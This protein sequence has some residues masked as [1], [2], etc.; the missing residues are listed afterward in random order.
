MKS[1][2]KIVISLLTCI[3]FLTGCNNQSGP[4]TITNPI[5]INYTESDMSGYTWIGN[6]IADFKTITI[7]EALRFFDEKGSGIL[8]FGYVG[9]PWCERAVPILNQAALQTEVTIWYV[10]LGVSV[11]KDTYNKMVEALSPQ[12]PK[13]EDGN[14]A[15]FVPFV[16]GIKNGKFTKSHCSLVNSFNLENDTDQMSDKEKEELK[17]D[18]LDIIYA[19]KD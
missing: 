15:F 19:T 8:Y 1:I 12:M 7:E 5:D 3:L 16:M 6:E 10:D 4:V 9:C 11:E 14:D 18:Y 2:N 13:D 17:Q